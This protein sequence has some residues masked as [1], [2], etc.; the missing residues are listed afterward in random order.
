MNAC[1]AWAWASAWAGAAW[2]IDRFSLQFRLLHG[3]RDGRVEL[4]RGHDVHLSSHPIVPE[5]AVLGASD[6]EIAGFLRN[7][8]RLD[9][10]ARHRVLL[11]AEIRQEETVD[12]VQGADADPDGPPL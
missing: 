7:E 5:A 4:R 2:A 6:L 1:G 3:R 11:H 10:H 8:P 12:H 9:R